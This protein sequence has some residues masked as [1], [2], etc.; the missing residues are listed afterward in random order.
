MQVELEEIAQ[1]ERKYRIRF[2]NSLSGYKGVHLIGSANKKGDENLAIFSSIVHLGANP[3]YLGFI[4]RPL[5]EER[6]TYKNIKETGYFTINHVHDAFMEK[7]H[8]TSAKFPKEVSE[9]ESCQLTPEYLREF[10]VPFVG[11]S[12]VKIGLKQVEEHQVKANGTILVVGEVVHVDVEESCIGVDGQLNL[13]AVEDVCVTGLNQYSTVRKNRYFPY[14]RVNEVPNF[15]AKRKPDSVAFDEET[16]KYH[17][18][19]LPYASNIGAPKIEPTNVSLW[20]N[21]SIKTYNYALENKVKEL[22]DQYDLLMKEYGVN[23]RL[24]NAKM[25]F[26]PIIGKVYHLYKDSLG[27]EFLSLIEPSHWDKEYLGSYAL[28]HEKTWELQNQ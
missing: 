5:V 19:V 24:Y 22:K 28:N 17:A 7:A 18:G 2:I 4:M 14:A 3:P 20:K 21:T 1:W 16:G 10:P 23:E 25:S 26:D 12:K 6:H 8:Y 9:F 27:E 11:E 15:K 13:E